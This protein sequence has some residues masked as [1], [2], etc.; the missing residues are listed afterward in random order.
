MDFSIEADWERLDNGSPED[1]ACFA[2]LG[3]RCNDIWLTQ[4]EDAFVK[5]AREKAHLSAYRLAEWLA[6][7]WWRLRWEPQAKSL[8]WAL[9]HRMTTIG[10]GYVWPNITIFSDGERVVLLARPTRPQPQEPLRYTAD[11]ASVI[12][13]GAFESGID[14]FIKRV[15]ERL[16]DN[17]LTGTNLDLVWTDVLAERADP[18]VAS[19]RRF[20]ALLGFDPDEA[21]EAVI[22]TL[23]ADSRI[24]GEK[25]MG[26]IAAN[27][28]RSGV[29]R[30]A[31]ELRASAQAHG[32]ETNP[33]DIVRLAPNT[34]LPPLGEAPA[35]RRGAEAA[36]ALRRQMRLGAAPISNRRLAEMAGVSTATITD[37]A[38]GPDFSFGLDENQSSGRVV[39][40]SKWQT[41]RRFDLARLLGD[42]LAGGAG[43]K[44]FPAT[45]TYTYRQK[46]QR[47]FAAELLCPFEGLEDML[48]G[49]Y[50]PDGIED[51]ANHYSVSE[52]TVRTLLVNHG[53]LDRESLDVEFEAEIAA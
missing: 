5:A 8:D 44:L 23:I 40:R 39:L 1:Q 26:E 19:R 32:F 16:R 25:E 12:R 30:T 33:G 51:A 2:A 47:S 48:H 46:L 35:W 20:E 49:D 45:N 42:R 13:A 7:N 27:R 14:R 38:A 24:L 36:Q 52:R 18:G 9:S 4:V 11:I 29:I 37:R 34:R 41:G 43:G 53:R 31:S 3:L 50:S 17:K 15:Q 10:G 21:E 28:S 22:E 6:S